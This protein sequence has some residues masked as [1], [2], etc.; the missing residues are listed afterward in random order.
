MKYFNIAPI[1]VYESILTKS[2][3]Q[4]GSF[5]VSTPNCA[6]MFTKEY[7][8]NRE[9]MYDNLSDVTD[10][11]IQSFALYETVGFYPYSSFM[12]TYTRERKV[13]PIYILTV[14]EDIEKI[15][16]TE[17]DCFGS[18][19]VCHYYPYN[20]HINHVITYHIFTPKDLV[21]F[22]IK[23]L[24]FAHGHNKMDDLQINKTMLDFY[25]ESIETR[26]VDEIDEILCDFDSKVKATAKTEREIVAVKI[27]ET[28]CPNAE[29]RYFIEEEYT[30]L[31]T[32]EENDD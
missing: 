12:S 8:K 18:D 26:G 1:E 10:E 27:M 31:L 13:E 28:L 22:V 20:Q 7:I 24:A 11:Q 30:K 15:Y 17:L 9:E 16:S 3:S 4:P 29:L 2:G 6:Y 25:F 21:D 14:V 23:S 19:P 32:E 5:S